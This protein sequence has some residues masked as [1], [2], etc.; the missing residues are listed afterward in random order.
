MIYEVA[1]DTF[2]ALEI[3]TVRTRGCSLVTVSRLQGFDVG[4]LSVPCRMA[5]EIKLYA[6]VQWARTRT[7][8]KLVEYKEGKV[9]SYYPS[10][11]SQRSI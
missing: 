2:G 3:G 8:W 1:L 11:A 4:V 10:Q 6:R 7:A 9:S 5:W